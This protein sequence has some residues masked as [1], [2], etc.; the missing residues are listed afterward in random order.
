MS[1][2][3]VSSFAHFAKPI[4]PIQILSE[5][6]VARLMQ[7]SRFGLLRD[8]VMVEVSLL[9]GLRN[10]EVLGLNLAH[11]WAYGTLRRNIIV[12]P[13]IAKG[14][15]ARE[16][17]IHPTLRADLLLYTSSICPDSPDSHLSQ[18]LFVSLK[19]GR[20][21]STRDFQRITRNLGIQ[22]LGRPVNPHML[23]HTFATRLL[24]NTNTRVVQIA[25]GHSSLQ[26]TQIYVHPSSDDI[27]RAVHALSC[28]G[29]PVAQGGANV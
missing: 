8:F 15:R 22:I 20:R 29:A 16:V 12:S 7:R 23:R 19:T 4:Q 11:I 10:A 2:S 17:P 18:P 14:G 9:A 28:P 27:T 24:Q 5:E 6:E 13:D 1:R 25:L 21:L 26:S 3:Y